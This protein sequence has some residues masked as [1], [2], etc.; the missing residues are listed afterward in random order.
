MTVPCAATS[1][2]NRPFVTATMR[3]R[4][5]AMTWLELDHAWMSQATSATNTTDDAPAMR[6]H[7]CLCHGCFAEAMEV[8]CF[9]VPRT[10]A[11]SE[12]RLS[13]AIFMLQK[14]LHLLCQPPATA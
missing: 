7:R 6:T 2:T 13:S 11:V 14:Q 1:R 3:R 4:S 5:A 9:S 10:E 8:S 12:S